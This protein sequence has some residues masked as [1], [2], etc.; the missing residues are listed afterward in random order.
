MRKTGERIL[1]PLMAFL[2]T[3]GLIFGQ[4]SPAPVSAEEAEVSDEG[5]DDGYDEGSDDGSGEDSGDDEEV[6]IPD[7]YYEP[8]QS[9]D[10]GGW[11]QG[12]AIQASSGVV[13]DMDTG[14]LLYA[15]NVQRKLYPASITKIMTCL[16]VLENA[17]NL[18]DVITCTADVYDLDDGASNIALQE[19][20]QITVRDALYALMLESA[21]DAANALADYVAGSIPAFADMMNQRAAQLGCTV[22]HFVNPNGLSNDEHYTCARDMALIAGA[23]YAN[24][25]FR[26]LI[27]TVEYEIKPTNMTEDSRWFVNHHRMIQTDSDYY[28]DFCKGGKTGFTEAA[29]NTLV[30]FGEK[31]GLRLVCVLMR[32]NGA[33]QNYLETTDLLNYGFDNFTHVQMD[34]A[35]PPTLADAMDVHYLGEGAS[36]MA[37]ELSQQI[38]QASGSGMA[39]VPNGTGSS[40]VSRTPFKG[41]DGKNALAGEFGTVSGQNAD[42]QGTEGSYYY[43]FGGW[44]VGC[45]SVVVNPVSLDLTLPWQVDTTVT[46]KADEGE[47]GDKE[48]A[49]EK[50]NEQA[51]ENV[52]KYV[53]NLDQKRQNFYQRNRTSII[54]TAGIVIIAVLLLLLILLV[55]STRN[56]RLK[57]KMRQAQEQ[58]RKREEEIESMTTAQIEQ[59]LRQ[60]MTSQGQ[61]P[62]ERPL[63]LL[64]KEETAREEAAKEEQE[65][66]S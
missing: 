57:K 36:L 52:G 19:G 22:T 18:D 2:L 30:T 5:T 65:Q 3:A 23:A 49:A 13:M 37:P 66:H 8:V 6:Y 24:E 21:N 51:W 12:E 43:T 58:A 40:S 1:W 56:Y 33:D 27:S 48:E 7:E 64:E 59:E 10:I 14:A 60:A 63:S 34:K 4:V 29:W 16:L 62:S 47:T 20:E 54:L 46:M 26:T 44:P 53:R 28:Q 32:G 50:E 38:A 9:N 15:K 39:T 42:I 45:R 31:N 61:N 25:G 11:P 41:E 35:A 17:P 55:R